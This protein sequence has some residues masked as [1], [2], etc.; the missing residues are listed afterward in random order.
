MQNPSVD[1]KAIVLKPEK[2]FVKRSHVITVLPLAGLSFGFHRIVADAMK[3]L[4]MM[5]FMALGAVMM[6]ASLMW[7]SQFFR[8]DRDRVPVIWLEN[9]DRSEDFGQGNE[10]AQYPKLPE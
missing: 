10:P 7:I 8:P 3:F 9:V 1:Q 2:F 6:V 5:C 4:K